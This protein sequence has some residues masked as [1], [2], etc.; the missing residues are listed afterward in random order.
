M[1]KSEALAA[2]LDQAVDTPRQWG[3]HDCNLWPADWV[4]RCG[5]ADPAAEWR[6]LYTTPLG[7]ARLVED[8]GGMTQ[9][10]CDAANG[11][12]LV[13]TPRPLAGDVGLIEVMTSDR[14]PLAIFG[15]CGAICM[16]AGQWAVV[17]EHGLFMAQRPV[18][19]AWR[20]PW[21][22]Q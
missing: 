19:A 6:G 4:V 22:G 12:G 1:G 10:W 15:R 8:A 11:V 13:V 18:I 3:V 7:A 14:D 20:V 21:L 16:G 2:W 5:H 9:L 17:S